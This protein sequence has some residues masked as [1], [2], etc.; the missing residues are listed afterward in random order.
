VTRSPSLHDKDL[1]N[2]AADLDCNTLYGRFRIDSLTGIQTGHRI[3]LTRWQDGCNGV[4][5]AEP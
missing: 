5:A 3:L 4:L 2:A 1:R